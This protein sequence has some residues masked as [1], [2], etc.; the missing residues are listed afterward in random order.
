MRHASVHDKRFAKEVVAASMSV[1]CAA[2]R[3]SERDAVAIHHEHAADVANV[4]ARPGEGCGRQ[5]G[6]VVGREAFRSEELECLAWRVGAASRPVERDGQLHLIR[7][8]RHA[9]NHS[10]QTSHSCSG[11]GVVRGRRDAKRVAGSS[12]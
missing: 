7:C 2:D 1:P 5:T 8:R 3:R 10:E 12:R 6:H 11:C 9:R 4:V